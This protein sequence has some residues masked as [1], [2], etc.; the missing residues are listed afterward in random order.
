[1]YKLGKK[2]SGGPTAA[3]ILEATKKFY[4]KTDAL[5]ERKI[6]PS[7]PRIFK[8]PSEEEIEELARIKKVQ[9]LSYRVSN[10]VSISP[11]TTNT[12][13]S[14]GV[15][16]CITSAPV[17]Y[18]PLKNSETSAFQ[19]FIKSPP[20]PPKSAKIR[21]KLMAF[22]KPSTSETPPPIFPRKVKMDENEPTTQ[23][24]NKDSEN[25]E[26]SG[27]PK[28]PPRP[29]L[30][31]KTRPTPTPRR[32]TTV[33]TDTIS[34]M[35][36]N[37]N[38]ADAKST[39]DLRA[40]PMGKYSIPSS[41]IIIAQEDS[42]TLDDPY[43]N[44][45]FTSMITVNLK[46]IDVMSTSWAPDS[47][48]LKPKP[49]R[50][51]I[52]VRPTS[53][54]APSDRNHIMEA[55]NAFNL[56]ET[57]DLTPMSMGSMESE[58]KIP[59]QISNDETSYRTPSTMGI[60]R[61]HSSITPL[62][63]T[64][65]YSPGATS[66]IGSGLSERCSSERNSSSGGQVMSSPT[67]S[68]DS[69]V[70]E[71]S[72]GS[73]DELEIQQVD[74]DF[75]DRIKRWDSR[76][77]LRRHRSS[78]KLSTFRAE[79]FRE[80]TSTNDSLSNDKKETLNDTFFDEPLLAEKASSDESSLKREHSFLDE[81][82]STEETTSSMFTSVSNRVNILAPPVTTEN[83]SIAGTNSSVH[84]GITNG[85]AVGNGKQVSVIEKN[86]RVIQWIHGCSLASTV[87]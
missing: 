58:A 87:C 20:R 44:T 49:K 42:D 31:K 60:K 85:K 55:K 41:S 36:S 30:E 80:K 5:K 22:E 47:E 67:T 81:L 46:P 2:S 10:V 64:S 57:V 52:P 21:Q 68:R 54:A 48:Y 39:P 65:H 3:E 37:L 24:E 8:S 83:E 43:K 1:M 19:P 35:I 71:A 77:V 53:L 11:P 26:N 62:M 76:S 84:G 34:S 13:D 56:S 75:E 72:G 63:R 74:K 61:S 82:N 78:P 33:L 17:Q 16:F 69:G 32:K 6:D 14:N 66:G 59:A 45:M 29:S 12:D 70:P 23:E 73:S 38:Y 40:I 79:P 50:L 4:V 51:R 86:A 18:N 15:T 9:A 28:P 25:K 27:K 7:E